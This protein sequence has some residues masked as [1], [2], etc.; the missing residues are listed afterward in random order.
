MQIQIQIQMK[1]IHKNI[2]RITLIHKIKT[3]NNKN[4]IINQKT[5]KSFN[6]SNTKH[7]K[8]ILLTKIKTLNNQSHKMIRNHNSKNNKLI[9]IQTKPFQ[10]NKYLKIKKYPNKT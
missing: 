2:N 3:F 8:I 4:I 7:N 9:R 5:K 1:I 10:I 6:F